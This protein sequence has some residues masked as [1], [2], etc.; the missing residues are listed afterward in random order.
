MT[1][2]R[3][4]VI[5]LIFIAVLIVGAFAFVAYRTPKTAEEA[6]EVTEKDEL[7]S[8]NIE[9]S[10]PSTPRE[11]MK[12]YNRYMVCL[13]G[14]ESEKMNEGEVRALGMK[15]RQMYDEKLLTEN[16]E[17]SHLLKLAQEL[18]AVLPQNKTE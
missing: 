18:S 6:T 8:K 1:K 7:M 10:Y 3:G 12:L 9:T 4:G 2:K 14:V 5:F 15:M 16:P 17:E 13:Y 11:V